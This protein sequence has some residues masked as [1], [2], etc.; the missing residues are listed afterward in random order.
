MKKSK[1]YRQNKQKEN[2]KVRAIEPHVRSLVRAS[3][4][5]NNDVV[6]ALVAFC[7]HYRFGSDRY[8]PPRYWRMEGTFLKCWDISR[9]SPIGIRAIRINKF[10]VFLKDVIFH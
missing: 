5:N 2:V 8:Q 4:N 1:R 9:R 3:E 10:F 7:A 6:T